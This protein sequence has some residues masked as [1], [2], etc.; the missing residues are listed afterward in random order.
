MEKADCGFV[1]RGGRGSIPEKRQMF[2]IWA[3]R[4]TRSDSGRFWWPVPAP[5]THREAATRPRIRVCSDS[6]FNAKM[7]NRAPQISA[8]RELCSLIGA[9]EILL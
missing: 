1:G 2:T 8:R 5:R 6:I 4:S 3:A 7:L 9:I